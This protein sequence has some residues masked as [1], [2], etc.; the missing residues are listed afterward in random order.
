MRTLLSIVDGPRAHVRF[1]LLLVFTVRQHWL[2][3]DSFPI[4]N[5]NILLAEGRGGGPG[6]D[7]VCLLCTWWLTIAR[8]NWTR[9]S[10]YVEPMLL[11]TILWSMSGIMEQWAC[12]GGCATSSFVVIRNWSGCVWL[13]GT[14]RAIICFWLNN[15]PW[16][17]TKYEWV[18]EL[19]IDKWMFSKQIVCTEIFINPTEGGKRF[20]IQ[21][22][23]FIFELHKD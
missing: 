15:F 1:A 19:G 22:F 7:R 11:R 2:H 12:C 4:R 16:T 14:Q 8:S 10:N 23:F 13:C 6:G 3:A 5:S 20:S 21:I 9:Y 18:V 17:I